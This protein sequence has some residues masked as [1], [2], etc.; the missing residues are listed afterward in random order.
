MDRR[1]AVVGL[2]FVFGERGRTLCVEGDAADC[3]ER[4]AWLSPFD[5]SRRES[6]SAGGRRRARLVRPRGRRR[7]GGRRRCCGSLSAA[8][9]T[10]GQCNSPRAPETRCRAAPQHSSSSFVFSDSRGAA[11]NQPLPFFFHPFLLTSY[12]LLN[13]PKWFLTGSQT[14]AS[15]GRRPTGC[16][17]CVIWCRRCSSTNKSRRPSRKPRKPSAW[18]SRS[19]PGA[20]AAGNQTGTVRTPSSLYVPQI[21]YLSRLKGARGADERKMMVRTRQKR[22]AHSSQPTRPGMR[23]ARVATLVS[24]GPVTDKETTPR[25]RFSSSSTGRTTCGSNP[26]RAPSGGSSL[27]ERRREPGSRGGGRSGRESRGAGRRRW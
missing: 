13:P 22:S 25:S 16:S 26:L 3:S 12:T 11:R 14:A 21:L 24:S 18:P 17:C 9:G 4:P 8:R 7:E 10:A 1:V 15:P 27:S 2:F 5:P 6:K 19:S 20:N 23:P